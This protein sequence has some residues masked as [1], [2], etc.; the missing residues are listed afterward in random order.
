MKSIIGTLKQK[1]SKF[2]G[3]LASAYSPPPNVKPEDWWRCQL[4][5]MDY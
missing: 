3:Y 1:V 5:R 2:F 4:D